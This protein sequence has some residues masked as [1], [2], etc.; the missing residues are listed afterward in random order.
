MKT[1]GKTSRPRSRLKPLLWL[2]AALVVS[3]LVAITAYLF[4]AQTA[5][6]GKRIMRNLG[7]SVD[8]AF[9][10]SDIPHIKANSQSDAIFALGYLHATERSWQLEMNRRIGSGRLSEVLG[11]DTVPIDRFIRTLG[12]KRAAERQF[13]RYPAATKHLL[14]AYADGVNAGNASLGWALPIEYFLT[15]S[16]PGH[17]SPTDSIAWMLM[18]AYDLGGNWQKELQRLELS[19]FL[20]TK[21]VWEVVPPHN[22]NDILSN[23][24]FAKMYRDIKVFNP[25]TVPAEEK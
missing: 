4:S 5:I 7:D 14:Q 21:Q 1:H 8:I 11:K 12:I 10:A 24:D 17:W 22:Q 23:V 9:D 16:K 19:R 13:D 3:V 6:S 18:M 2:F 15:G 20:S 25:T